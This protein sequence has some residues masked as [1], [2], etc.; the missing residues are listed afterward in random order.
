MGGET[1]IAREEN[2]ILIINFKNERTMKKYLF[3][4]LAMGLVL[5]SC[6]SDEPFA[7]GAGEEVQASFTISVPD[8]MGTRAA[9]H[10]SAEGGYSNGAG[11]LNYTVV[12]LNDANKVMY[13][14]TSA[15][16]GTTATFNPTVV[17]NYQY[18]ILAYATFG[19]AAI[20]APTVGQTIADTDA[21]NNIATLKTIN[22]ESEDA[23]FCNATIVGAPEM[24]ATLK[25]PFGKLRLVATDYDKLQDL[26]LDVKSV[27]VTYG[28]TVVMEEEFDAFYQTFE[29]DGGNVWSADKAT[30]AEAADNE[31][32]VFVDYL[33]AGNGEKM[34][35]F[36]IEVTYDDNKTIYTRTFAQDIPVKRNYL[37]TLRGDFF[38]TEAALTLTVNEM[39]ET[40]GEDINFVSVSNASQLQEAI[41]N[42]G[43]GETI[44]LT[45]DIDLND[46]FGPNPA[47]TRAA[48]DP[49][50]TIVADKNLTI[51][52]SGKKL[53]ATSKAIGQ[54]YNMIDVRGTLTVKNGNIEYEHK[55]ANMEWNNS[56]N[57]FNVTAGGVLNLEGVTAKNLGGSDM[58]FVAH[59]NNWG[60]VTLNVE[61]SN[62]ES[63]Y[64]A[65]RVF[66]SGYDKNNVTIK[67]STLN[68]GNYAFWVHNYTA[69][70][71]GTQ[72]KADAQKALLNFDIFNGT[73]TFVGKNN[74]PIRYGFTDA[75]YLEASGLRYENKTYYIPSANALVALSSKTIKE[76]EQVMLT[77][78][79]D[80]T[81][82][83]FNGLSAFNPENNNTFDGQGYTVS[84]WT[85]NSG[86]SDMGFIKNWVGP[87][88]NINFENC[89]LKTGGRSAIVAAKVYGNIENVHVE[90]CSIEDSYW[91]CGLIVGLYN[92]GSVT[93]CSATNSS[94]KSNGGTAAIAG[95]V[96]E[97]AGTRSFTNCKVEG[98][99]INNTGAYGEAYSGAAI[100]GII[101]VSNSTIKFIGCQQINNTFEGKHIYEA[102]H[103]PTGDGNTIVIE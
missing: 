93:N 57:I 29:G 34:Y 28:T 41:N 71:F 45:D 92:S 15:G 17:R 26:G 53:S 5:T 96:N 78:D 27:K 33:P 40:P 101:N 76:G 54:N 59:L 42:G 74:T 32:T 56:T 49:S 2:E 7:P 67:N 90:N 38:T 81:G 39:F 13:S 36:E 88:K 95:V 63:N 14:A 94:V 4:A 91:A 58:G 99:T 79:I 89:H 11:Q 69:A 20:A 23:Y 68:G 70:D 24:S 60:E 31:L 21:I 82:V 3:S 22:D 72:E 102:F 25:R 12:L 100:V 35:P 103:A 19:D 87:I 16:N 44:V 30:Y 97:S 37:T 1:P 61:N 75:I 86:A 83:E 85:N 77:A 98:C 18:K 47:P 46:L 9:D 8:A 73:N 51:D 43:N 52:L 66:N 10:S 48:T 64:V 84:N 50:I 6:Q 62:L 65:V 55:G 80:L